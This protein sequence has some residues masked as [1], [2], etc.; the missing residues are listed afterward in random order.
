MQTELRFYDKTTDPETIRNIN[1]RQAL[2]R[3]DTNIQR[4]IIRKMLKNHPEGLTDLEIC[5]FTGFSRSSV[6]ARRNE[7]NNVKPIGYAKI[8]TADG[9]RLNTLWS[10][11][12]Y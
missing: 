9:D 2:E 1:H 12:T 5:N 7:I 6:T 3:E 11:D 10:I 8:V 4:N